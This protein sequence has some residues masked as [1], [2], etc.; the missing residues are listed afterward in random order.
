MIKQRDN[1]DYLF[2]VKKKRYIILIDI[3]FS[4]E[5]CVKNIYIYEYL[6]IDS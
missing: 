2:N 6:H 3:N 1:N 5:F 4:S